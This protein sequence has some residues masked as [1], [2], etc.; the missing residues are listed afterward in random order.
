M[1]TSGI[2]RNVPI[3][4]PWN[5]NNIGRILMSKGCEMN[6][7]GCSRNWLT[8]RF[9]IDVSLI[10]E[11]FIGVS[12]GLRNTTYG[13]YIKTNGTEMSVRVTRSGHG[14]KGA[15]LE[16]LKV[17][18]FLSAQG[19]MPGWVFRGLNAFDWKGGSKAE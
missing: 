3:A 14:S 12:C 9:F 13:L 18:G 8:C 19:N 5:H 7:C 6:C 17:S 4:F 1:Y 2:S 10:Q 15:A 16:V 11:H